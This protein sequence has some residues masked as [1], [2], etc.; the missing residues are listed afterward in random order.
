MN[1]NTS[2]LKIEQGHLSDLKEL[3]QIY[4]N[5]KIALEKQNIFQWTDNYPTLSILKKD[6]EKKHLFI[7]KIN[8]EIIGAINISE[9]QEKEYKNIDW[10]FSNKK[11]LVIHRLVIDPKKQRNGFA[12]KAMA[13]AEE[14][15]VSNQY[16]SIR[17]DVYSKNN[18]TVNFYKKRNFIIRG[19]VNFPERKHPFYCM[20][21]DLL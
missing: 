3:F 8:N 13:F 2:Q 18:Y 15:A 6:L 19:S 16:T 1:I 7:L 4:K 14:Y 10:K 12:N 20:E 5:G 17:L 9:E 21:K 11:V